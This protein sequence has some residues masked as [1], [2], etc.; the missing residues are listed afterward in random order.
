MTPKKF[1][2]P[3]RASPDRLR[4]HR[5]DKLP[6]GYF[7]TGCAPEEPASASPAGV[8]PA[9]GRSGSAV[10]DQRTADGVLTVCPT[11]GGNHNLFPS[12]QQTSSEIEHFKSVIASPRTNLF[13][14]SRPND[15]KQ[16]RKY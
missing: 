4:T 16:I 14:K 12:S 1:G 8:H 11:R 2:T 13:R 6:P 15:G 5:H 10:E 9:A 3:R 7:L